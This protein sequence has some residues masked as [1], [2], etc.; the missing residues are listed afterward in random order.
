[1]LLFKWKDIIQ[2]LCTKLRIIGHK[3]QL[4]TFFFNRDNIFNF[5]R[6]N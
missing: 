1:M 5:S 2:T 3:K 4:M 6:P